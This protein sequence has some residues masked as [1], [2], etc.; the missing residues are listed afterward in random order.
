MPSDEQ[1]RS[2]QSIIPSVKTIGLVYDPDHSS[3]FVSQAQEDA[4]I[5]GVSLVTRKISR[6]TDLP[7]VLRT[8]LP[9][10]DVLWLIRDATVI[11][12]E[13]IPF[14]LETALSY[15]RPVF[16]FSEGL[17]QHGALAAISVNYVEL[18]WQAGAIAGGIIRDKSPSAPLGQLITPRRT[19]LALN[20]GTSHFL[21]IPPSPKIVQLATAV[22]GGS[23]A[24]AKLNRNDGDEE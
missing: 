20:L 21:G 1:V 9:E 15:H 11:T 4:Q 8:F 19:Q 7:N 23:S 14:I 10:I 13:S 3:V 12:E 24:L 22:F 17:A 2:I 5:L 6:T 18:G 16:G